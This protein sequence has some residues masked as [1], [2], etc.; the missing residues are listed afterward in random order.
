MHSNELVIPNADGPKIAL[1][2]TSASFDS[3]QREGVTGIEADTEAM[4]YIAR[5]VGYVLPSGSLSPLV[6][7]TRESSEA[8][9]GISHW[10]D[11]LPNHQGDPN[12][13]RFFPANHLDKDTPSSA[14]REIF[15]DAARRIGAPALT[16]VSVA[17]WEEGVPHAGD[18]ATGL[19]LGQRPLDLPP[20]P[21]LLRAVGGFFDI[22]SGALEAIRA[23]H[24]DRNMPEPFILTR[25]FRS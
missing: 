9:S 10:D 7:V 3:A 8:R 22:K 14:N 4:T 16:E 25:R 15:A 13:G 18:F 12:T 21:S 5:R 19:L 24:A 17:S 20:K 1:G 2:M 6:I 23:V 11:R